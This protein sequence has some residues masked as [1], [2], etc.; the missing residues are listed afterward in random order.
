MHSCPLPPKVTEAVEAVS[1]CLPP[2]RPSDDSG[3]GLEEA[4]VVEEEERIMMEMDRDLEDHELLAL[5][6]ELRVKRARTC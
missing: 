3:R 5:A 6:K 1:G 4:D 2:S